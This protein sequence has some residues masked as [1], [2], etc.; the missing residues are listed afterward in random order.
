M[1]T[2]KMRIVALCLFLSMFL[3]GVAM[4]APMTSNTNSMQ[5]SFQTGAVAAVEVPEGKSP[6]TGLDYT[7]SYRPVVVQIDNTPAARPHLNMSEADIV[8][9]M[10]YWGPAYTRYTFIYHDNHPSLVASVRSARTMHLQIRQEWDAPFV[11]W[12][13]QQD[14]G[15]NI[16]DWFKQ[17]SVY[18][19]LL[20]DGVGKVK[21]GGNKT[22]LF[23]VSGRVSPHNAAV[24]LEQ[25]VNEY[26]PQNEDGTPYEPK[27]HAYKFSDS[28]SYGADTAVKIDIKYN[29]SDASDFNPSY[30]FNAADGVY[31]RWYNGAEMY[32]GETQKRIVASNVIVQYAD[33]TLYNG[34]SSRP[35]IN[36]VGSGEA[37]FFINGRH[38]HGSWM[39]NSMGDRTV[40]MDANGEEITLKPG[41]TFI[42]VVPTS[43]SITYVKDDGQSVESKSGAPATAIEYDPNESIEDINEVEEGEI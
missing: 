14:E 32:D 6:I 11:F 7:G 41:K 19:K 33:L 3:S 36:F 39:R 31:E 22:P 13:G 5:K 25:L 10:I 17:Y 12:G 26:W 42:Q 1:H 40:F 2:Q 21:D 4:A 43:H 28:P 30:T 18:S 9:E 35:V 23:R 20:F 34:T 37:D 27:V 15:T 16:Y 24:N 8:Y 38:I 29:Q